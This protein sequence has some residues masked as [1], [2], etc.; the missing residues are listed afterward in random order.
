M[1]D[2]TPYERLIA[3]ALVGDERLFARQ[4]GVEEAWRIVEPLLTRRPVIRTSQGRGGLTRPIGWPHCRRRSSS[5]CCSKFFPIVR[6]W[7]DGLRS[8]SSTPRREPL[9]SAGSS[10]FAISGGST[11]RR[12]LEVLAERDDIEWNRVY[13]FQV[14]ERVAP[15]GDPDRNATM[16]A[17]TLLLRVC[18]CLRTRRLFLMPV[19]DDDLE[20]AAAALCGD[21]GPRHRIADRVRS[22]PARA[23]AMMDTP[24]R[25]SR[26]IR[27]SSVTD[28]AVG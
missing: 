5:R 20:A 10:R 23:R 3:D 25:S 1:T 18:R 12:M 17:E 13:L 7:P 6:R 26:A 15:D 4:D 19:T 24:R 28:R 11:P 2:P 27:S 9:A 16:L 21:D 8:S 22:D 14:D